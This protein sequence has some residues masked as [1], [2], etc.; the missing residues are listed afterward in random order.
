MKKK[1]EIVFK[2]LLLKVLT[3]VSK[4]PKSGS[5]PESNAIRK[6]LVIRLNRIGDALVTTPLIAQ[7]K[8]QNKFLVDVLADEKNYFVFQNSPDVNKLFAHGSTTSTFTPNDLNSF[9]IQ[10]AC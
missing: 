4:K 7:I 3:L 2:K 8:K 1:L 5:I 9:M 6:V 10:Y